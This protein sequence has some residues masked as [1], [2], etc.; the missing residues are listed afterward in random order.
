MCESSAP[1]TTWSRCWLPSKSGWKARTWTCLT[2]SRT[3]TTG[4]R[5]VRGEGRRTWRWGALHHKALRHP[6]SGIGD[7]GALLDQPLPEAGGGPATLNSSGV[8]GTR[9]VASD[10][11]YLR[12]WD[13]TSGAGYRL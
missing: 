6:L 9:I 13:G 10:P 11:G 8:A 2:S 3:G 12:N 5:A 4:L 7:L 1:T